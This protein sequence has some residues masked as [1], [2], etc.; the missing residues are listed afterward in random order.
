[1]DQRQPSQWKNKDPS[2]KQER[3]ADN[4]SN[5]DNT[6]LVQQPG[7]QGQQLNSSSGHSWS[8]GRPRSRLSREGR[9][10]LEGVVGSGPSGQHGRS[11]VS[12]DDGQGLGS[13]DTSRQQPKKQ[14]LPLKKRP[15][16]SPLLH[17]TQNASGDNSRLPMKVAQLPPKKSS[18]P[19]PPSPPKTNPSSHVIIADSVQPLAKGSNTEAAICQTNYQHELS[20]EPTGLKQGKKLHYRTSFGKVEEVGNVS[21]PKR[22]RLGWGQGLKEYER[23][24]KE[25]KSQNAA[26]VG[27]SG[28][29]SNTSMSTTESVVSA[30]AVPP[31][32]QGCSPP[33]GADGDFVNSI[34]TTTEGADSDPGTTFKSGSKTTVSSPAAVP[35]VSLGC[36]PPQVRFVREHGGRDFR[37]VSCCFR[38]SFQRNACSCG[39]TL[40]D[41][42]NQI[43]QPMDHLQ[44][45]N[46]P[47]GN[48]S[49]TEMKA[50]FPQE[51]ASG[52]ISSSDKNES[53]KISDLV[54][55]SGVT[56]TEKIDPIK[57]CGVKMK[58]ILDIDLNIPLDVVGG[59]SSHAASSSRHLHGPRYTAQFD[60]NKPDSCA[61]MEEESNRERA[62]VELGGNREIACD[63]T[64]AQKIQQSQ[65]IML[66]GKVIY[67]APASK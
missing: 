24:M 59:D 25:K 6:G 20:D 18:M 44:T 34:M 50:P 55:T 43:C 54:E 41:H 22:S 36:S 64:H 61:A 3:L 51:M 21:A 67:Q 7:G 38:A 2:R 15:L 40:P 33:P 48:V 60:L 65:S 42:V 28:D 14:F 57:S 30:A 4:S 52:I 56:A 8:I 27:A 49:A 66:F 29:F 1:M 9:V 35:A 62:T 39:L 12:L 26:A 46:P 16:N 19:P 45:H 17:S 11:D 32:S 5:V 23:M 63:D 10:S 37:I 53:Q 31:L 13:N 47:A 58:E